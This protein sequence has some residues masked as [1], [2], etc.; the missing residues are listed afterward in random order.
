M[1]RASDLVFTRENGKP[2]GCY[3]KAWNRAC[4]KSG[5]GHMLWFCKLCHQQVEVA[6]QPW[7]PEKIP[8][9][10]PECCGLPRRWKYKGLILHDLRRTGV[11]NLRR[12]GVPESIAMM[13]SGHRTREV[14]E[15][16]NIKD[17]R[18]VVEAMERLEQFHRAED[19]KLQ[20]Q[21]GGKPT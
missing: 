18:D 15:R 7:P 2:L 16:Y 8:D 17:R 4:I 10:R 13:I 19:E 21:Y 5:L 20:H 12:A 14:F 3:R 9:E 11:R 1:N 6:K